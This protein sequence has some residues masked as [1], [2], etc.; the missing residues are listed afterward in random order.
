MFKLQIYFLKKAK[1][2]FSPFNKLNNKI[3]IEIK[4]QN[5]NAGFRR[6]FL[7]NF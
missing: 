1:V 2:K 4:T 6:L 7:K 3:E 5:N